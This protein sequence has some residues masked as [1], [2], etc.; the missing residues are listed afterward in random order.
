MIESARLMLDWLGHSRKLP[1]AVAAAADMERGMSAALSRPETRTKDIRGAAD[2]QGM[3]RAI[4]RH[5]EEA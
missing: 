4:V 1:A 5:I 3:T 2:T